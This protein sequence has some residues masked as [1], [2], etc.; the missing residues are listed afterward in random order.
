MLPAGRRIGIQ[1]DI[2]AGSRCLSS[3]LSFPSQVEPSQWLACDVLC[4]TACRKCRLRMLHA[5]FASPTVHL[6][7]C[8]HPSRRA[9]RRVQRPPARVTAF[10]SPGRREG[11]PGLREQRIS[12][13]WSSF[14][15]SPN[16]DRLLLSSEAR[17]FVWSGQQPMLPAIS[18]HHTVPPM[19]FAS[20]VSR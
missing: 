2:Q 7:I 5:P 14:R 17:T 20:A 11:P 9:V 10:G 16:L 6:P 12:C 1:A 15:R 3:Y 8:S 19:A 13:P 4:C 18:T